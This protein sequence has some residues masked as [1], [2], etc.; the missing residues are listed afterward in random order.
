MAE[1]SPTEGLRSLSPF[2]NVS[3]SRP[4]SGLSSSVSSPFPLHM[5]LGNQ[6]FDA[7]SP[8]QPPQ[9]I[10]TFLSPVPPPS[11]IPSATNSARSTTY[12]SFEDDSSDDGIDQTRSHA[13]VGTSTRPA[14]DGLKRDDTASPSPNASR[15]LTSG[16]IH[17][18]GLTLFPVPAREPKTPGAAGTPTSITVSIGG[19]SRDPSY[20]RPSGVPLGGGTPEHGHPSA[21]NHHPQLPSDGELSDLDL[22]SDFAASESDFGNESDSGWSFAGGSQVGGSSAAP[23]PR[24]QMR[25]G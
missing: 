21:Q 19:G 13:N 11:Q 10:S 24:I 9:R 6:S 16:Q 23:S 4:A 17:G 12:L 5:N 8:L 14:E 20:F 18:L 3:S 25:R 1:I 7:M 2:S 22:M 15:T